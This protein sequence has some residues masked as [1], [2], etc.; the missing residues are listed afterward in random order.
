MRFLPLAGIR[1]SNFIVNTI[2]ELIVIQKSMLY[3]SFLV[4]YYGTMMNCLEI[5]S[6][7]L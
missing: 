7:F 2:V 6:N 3:Y 5:S 1:F 4:L